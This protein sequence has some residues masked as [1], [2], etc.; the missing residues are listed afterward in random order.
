[1]ISAGIKGNQSTTA[2]SHLTQRYPLITVATT[3]KKYG[4][5]KFPFDMIW[6]LG[7][8]FATTG[9]TVRKKI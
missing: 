4:A 9:N 3:A 1:M 8:L 6:Y 2:V 7:V 5:E